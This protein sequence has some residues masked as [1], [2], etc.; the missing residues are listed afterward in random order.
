MAAAGSPSEV[1]H[2]EILAEV[3]DDAHVRARQAFGRTFV[4]SE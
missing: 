4:W 3:Y 2:D 1:L